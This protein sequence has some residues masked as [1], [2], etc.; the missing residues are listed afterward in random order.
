MYHRMLLQY[1]NT[2]E[3]LFF[4]VESVIILLF[5]CQKYISL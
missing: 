3:S 2:G 1:L 4:S 5:I